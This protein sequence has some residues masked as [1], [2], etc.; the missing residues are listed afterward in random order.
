M[1][2]SMYGLAIIYLSTYIYGFKAFV[3]LAKKLYG[4]VN[5]QK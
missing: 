4:E 2:I 1:G 5:G 3:I